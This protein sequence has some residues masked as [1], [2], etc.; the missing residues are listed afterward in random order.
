MKSKIIGQTVLSPSACSLF[1]IGDQV[2]LFLSPSQHVAGCSKTYHIPTTFVLSLS[3]ACRCPPFLQ[4]NC[5][6]AVV[7]YE[8][9]RRGN[10]TTTTRTTMFIIIFNTTITII[11]LTTFSLCVVLASPPPPP[12][13]LTHTH[14]LPHT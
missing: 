13:P 6:F 7:V 1:L 14:T 9:V 4:H 12:P 10:I 2:F 3:S 8:Q 5:N 11:I